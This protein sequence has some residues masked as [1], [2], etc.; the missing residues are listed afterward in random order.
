MLIILADCY[1]PLLAIICAVYLKPE[2]TA[3]FKKNLTEQRLIWAFLL[4]YCYVYLFASVES[5]FDWWLSMGGNF[6]SHTAAVVVLGIAILRVNSKAGI[7][8]FIS[9][10]AY[11]YLMTILSYHSWFDV[12]STL[13][14]CTPCWW[15][16]SSLKRT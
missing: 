8:A 5:H 9:I 2:L 14:I 3:E 11:G 7:I 1:T 13:F 15:V 6:S 4:A 12:L 16:L 10:I